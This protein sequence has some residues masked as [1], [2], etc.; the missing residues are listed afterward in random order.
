MDHSREKSL[1]LR[2]EKDVWDR[3]AKE[4]QLHKELEA[5]LAT[6]HDE[7]VVLDPIC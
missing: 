7:V 4:K 2:R 6:T 5:Q 1:F 3:L